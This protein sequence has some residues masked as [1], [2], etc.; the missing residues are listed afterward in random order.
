V[1]IILKI[2]N[3]VL[4][5]HSRLFNMLY[6]HVATYLKLPLLA[7]VMIL[8]EMSSYIKKKKKKK[9]NLQTFFFLLT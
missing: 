6:L 9:K 3:G 2:L 4:F 1:S 7:K 5:Y 8:G